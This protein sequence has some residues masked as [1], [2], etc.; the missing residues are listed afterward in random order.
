MIINIK[1]IKGKLNVKNLKLGYQI[2]IIIF[3]IVFTLTNVALY[4]TKYNVN[5][6]FHDYLQKREINKNN[7][8]F[9]SVKNVYKRNGNFDVLT[10]NNGQGWFLLLNKDSPNEN[11]NNMDF[12]DEDFTDLNITKNLEDLNSQLN[13]EDNYVLFKPPMDF[14][15]KVALLNP[16]NDLIIG[17]IPEGNTITKEIILNNKLI[18][19]LV[20]QT[21]NPDFFDTL[22]DSFINQQSKFIYIISGIVF[23]FA[24]LLIAVIINFWLSP[25]KQMINGAKEISNGNYDLKINTNLKNEIGILAK[26]FNNMSNSIKNNEEIK[27]NMI[28]DI[29]HE[30]RTPITIIKAEIESFIDEVREPTKDNLKEVLNEID[31]L[32]KLVNEIHQI[33]LYDLKNWTYEKERISLIEIYKTVK[34]NFTTNL[35]DKSIILTDI[36]DG[37][38]IINGDKKRIAQLFNNLFENTLKYTN[39]KGKLN[40]KIKESP[41]NIEVIFEDSDPGVSDEQIKK[42]FDRFY[43]VENSRNKKFGGSG[44]GLTL[45][46]QIVESHDGKISAEHSKLGGICF[47]IKFK[48]D[49]I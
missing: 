21:F 17:D 22:D 19:K 38:C 11:K 29:S 45:C 48:K 46:K 39:E 24:L 41:E 2:F 28:A 40:I 37:K 35:Q 10:N 43:R 16:N 1:N 26:S 33:A 20:F 30:L 31:G 34:N 8:L 7:D 14:I 6:G 4:A 36:F 27:K 47:V 18:G 32:S 13:E 23:F 9:E 15:R 12:T 25:I 49:K 5:E 42:I 3:L 44:L